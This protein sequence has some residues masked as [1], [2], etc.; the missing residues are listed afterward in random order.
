[1]RVDQRVIP[2]DESHSLAY[3]L[4]PLLRIALLVKRNV[5]DFFENR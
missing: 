2:K 4:V 3:D 1:M 5:N